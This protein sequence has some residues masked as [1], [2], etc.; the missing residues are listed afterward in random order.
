MGGADHRLAGP[1]LVWF[2][3]ALGWPWSWLAL[4][5]ACA[6][7]VLCWPWA[8]LGMHLAGPGMV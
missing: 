6:E 7:P 8:G 5:W 4:D 2:M 1:R 3:M